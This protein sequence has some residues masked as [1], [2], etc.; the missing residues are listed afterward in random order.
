MDTSLLL[1]KQ[2]E[3]VAEL[4]FISHQK[5]FSDNRRTTAEQTYHEEYQKDFIALKNPTPIDPDKPTGKPM[6][7]KLADTTAKWNNKQSKQNADT[8][9]VVHQAWKSQYAVMDRLFAAMQQ[10]ISKVKDEIN[11][12]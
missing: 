7:D 8:A 4:S 6:A 3:V 12:G 10:C 11:R 5:V 2:A 9:E 1:G